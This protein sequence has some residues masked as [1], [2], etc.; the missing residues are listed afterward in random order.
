MSPVRPARR[1]GDRAVPDRGGLV[2]LALVRGATALAAGSLGALVW[3]GSA[4]I[5]VPLAVAVG[6]AVLPSIGLVFLAL[7]LLV[8]AYAV[9]MPAGSP[10]LLAFVAGLHAVFVLYLLLLHLPLHGWISVAA[11]RELALSFLRRQVVA[12]PV[13]L[14]ALLL[15]GAGSSLAVVLGGVAAFSGWALWLVLGRRA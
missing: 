1:T 5:A 2:P 9:N 10:W 6:A 7:L 4:W 3:G 11:L 14:L 8:V 15:G 12:Q 13:A